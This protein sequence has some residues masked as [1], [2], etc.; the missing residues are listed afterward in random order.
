MNTHDQINELLVD[1]ALGELPEQQLPEIEAHLVECQQCRAELKQL[2]AVL[3][4]AA[5]MKE[6]S[7]NAQMCESAE[8]A[9]LEA[10]ESHETKQQIPGPNISLESIWRTIMKDRIT[11]LAAAAAIAIIVLGG[12]TFWPDGN[13]E[14]GRW[15][16]VPSAAAQEIIAELERIEA[17]VYRDQAV[18]VGRYGSTH[19]SGTWSRNYEA[20]DRSREDRY[21]EHTDEDTYGE[22][23]PDSVLQHITYKVPYGQDL[24]QFGVSYEHQCYTIRIIEGGA[25]ERDP[26]EKLRFYV[27][28]LDR[29]DRILDM[30]T[31]DGQKCVGFEVDTSKYGDNPEGRVDRVWFDVQTKLPARIEKHGRPVTGSPGKTF[32]F[33][34][35]QFE[36]YVQIP[37]EMFEPEI[38]DGFINAEP[39]EVHAAKEKEEKGQMIYADV[40]AGL[41]DEVAAAL[42]SV[43]TAIYRERF[44]FVRDGN[45]LFTNGERIHLSQ[46]DWRKDRFSGEQLQRSEW[47]VTDKEDWGETSFDFNDRN[48]RLIQT[49]VN[50]S[51]RSYKVITHGSRSHPNNPMDRIIFLA[52]WI[53]RADRFFE[54]EQIE[55]IECFGFELSAKKYGTNPDTSKH[56]LWFDKDTKLPVKVESDWLQ[57]DGPRR[58]VKDQFEW[59]PELPADLFIPEIPEGFT[60]I[61]SD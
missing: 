11:K 51:D 60:A 17:L 44:G 26:I 18:F 25:Y 34:Q 10:V 42:S 58:M 56:R 23:D 50:F 15:W 32:T 30:K 53:D 2:E 24:I 40:P 29:A 31:F 55:G 3:Q 49:I 28:L 38:P 45:W 48:F 7:A 21:Y 33:I 47:F 22:S 35:D 59:N 16:L 5:S 8:Q 9:V 37:V 12:V 43:K 41:K 14:S 27:N 19:V 57:D 36:Y 13:L 4:C 46:Y 61:E 20:K 39:G 54:N 6:L 1:Y 52:G